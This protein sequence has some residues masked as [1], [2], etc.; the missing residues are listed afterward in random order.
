[1][2][3]L[4]ISEQLTRIP[5][6]PLAAK[7]LLRLIEDPEASPGQLARLV[8][9]DPALSARVMRLAN[10][11]HY[12]VHD[13]VN[14]AARAVILLGFSTVRGVAA[15]SATTLL[16]EGVDLGSADY[17]THAMTV[18][19][20]ASVAGD[21]LGLPSNESFS[22]GL[23]HDVGADL[24]HH[25]DPDQYDRVLASPGPGALAEAE[26]SAY[27]MTHA[28]AGAIALEEWHFPR[29]FVR[30][31][32]SHHD[33]V[34]SAPPLAQAIILGEAIANQIEPLGLA[35]GA[36]DLVGTMS[37]LGLPASLRVQL[38]DRARS[39][40]AEIGDFFGNAA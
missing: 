1:M 14:S 32:R 36:P 2:A 27:G 38:V 13:G 28:E 23:L 39:S 12:G 4:D 6:Q 7:L 35:E 25:A 16:T 26:T 21:A 10:S 17:W 11:P 20:A 24:F 34:S 30:A 37:S 31:I 18:A 22:A 3:P 9:M 40:V 8:E 19:A 29:A 5:A 15:A 33:A